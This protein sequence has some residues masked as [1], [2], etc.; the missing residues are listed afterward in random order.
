MPDITLY[1]NNHQTAVVTVTHADMTAVDLT[2][3][4]AAQFLAKVN[5]FDSDADAVITKTL[6]AGN[7]RVTSA[8]AGLMEIEFEPA[9]TMDSHDL[10]DYALN[11]TD[12]A[13]HEV[14]VAIGMILFVQTAI[15]GA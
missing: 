7:I 1:R 12:A 3:L 8:V 11:I 4:K 6:A 9:D 2:G 14:T 10:L 15:K 13:N 5:L